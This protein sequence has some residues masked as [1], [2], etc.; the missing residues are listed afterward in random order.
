MGLCLVLVCAATGLWAQSAPVYGLFLGRELLQIGTFTEPNPSRAAYWE[1]WARG[2]A[3]GQLSGGQAVTPGNQSY[4]APADSQGAYLSEDFPAAAARDAEF[5][6]GAYSLSVTGANAFSATISLTESPAA[7]PAA[8][9]FPP[10]LMLEGIPAGRDVPLSWQ[11]GADAREGDAVMVALEDANGGFLFNTPWPGQPG[12]LSGLATSATLPG[13][14]LTPGNVLE[15]K[16]IVFRI[17]SSQ[18]LP[19]GGGL[20]MAGSATAVSEIVTVSSA[21]EGNDV[22]I[23]ELLEG[24]DFSQ[25]SQAVPVPD[26]NGP[27]A[28]EASAWASAA[29][30]LTNAAVAPP[31]LSPMPLGPVGS[32]GLLWRTNIAFGQ[33]ADLSAAFPAGVYSWAFDGTADG[34]QTASAT[35]AAGAWPQPLTVAN[36]SACQTNSFTNDFVVQWSAPANA[37]TNDYVEF[38]VLD[39]AQDEVFRTPNYGAGES[40]L[41]GTSTQVVIPA[42]TLYDGLDYEAQLR[43]VQVASTDTQSL[44]GATG[45]VGRYAETRFPLGTQ[46]GPPLEILTTNLPD[47]AVGE[48]Y[49][50]QLEASGGRPPLTWS[51]I[52]GSLP[53]ALATDSSGVIQGYPYTNGDFSLTVQATDSLGQTAQQPLLLSVTGVL[54]QLSF[55]ATNLP[56]VQD[57]LYYLVQLTASGGLGPLSWSIVSGQL[58]LGLELD[59]TTGLIGGLAQEAGSF[60]IQVALRDASGQT[61]IQS[62]VLD[63]P[64]VT[65][66]PVLRFTEFSLL[67]G[68]ALLLGLNSQAGE[69][70]TVEQSPD[71]GHWTALVTTNMPEGG[72]LELPMPQGTAA[73]YRA[74]RG[75]PQPVSNPLNVS[76][77]LD[78]NTTASALLTGSGLSLSLTNAAGQAWELDVPTNAVQDDTTIQMTALQAVAGLPFQGGLIGGVSFAPEGLSLL[79]PATL[80]MRLPAAVPADA[81]AFGFSGAGLN[82]QLYPA[83]ATNNTM[84]F[85]ILHFSGVGAA[86]ATPGETS[87][88]SATG[89]CNS[90]NQFKQLLAGLVGWGILSTPEDQLWTLFK[91]WFDGAIWPALQAAQEDDRLL[92]QAQNQFGEWDAFSQKY[93]PLSTGYYSTVHDLHEKGRSA[94]ARAFANAVNASEYRALSQLRPWQAYRMML[95]A[96]RARALGLNVELPGTFD[97]ALMTQRFLRDFVFWLE[98]PLSKV[99]VHSSG[100][101]YFGESVRTDP[102]H[103]AVF[104]PEGDE[105]Q[106]LEGASSAPLSYLTWREASEPP[107]NRPVPG[108]GLLS[109]I[110]LTLTPNYPPPSG[111]PCSTDPAWNDPLQPNIDCSFYAVDPIQNMEVWSK[112]KKAWV[113]VPALGGNWWTVFQSKH[114]LE[115]NGFRGNDAS[116]AARIGV[117]FA[118][119]LWEY[120][121]GAGFLF[122]RAVFSQPLT[123]S[124]GTIEEST[125]ISLWYMPIIATRPGSSLAHAWPAIRPGAADVHGGRARRPWRPRPD[126]SAFVRPR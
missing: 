123:D 3:P 89:A 49:A 112:S 101:G 56:V 4:A 121:G 72:E 30:R 107:E 111:D 9:S 78:T 91:A 94:L 122:A 38:V 16:L 40:P 104:W 98:L 120:F 95:V 118:T 106:P 119:P 41:P 109:G 87:K 79:N 17:A 108:E 96:N 12:A 88:L 27:Y 50:A 36:W 54:P 83:Q 33:E 44:P 116:G 34:H 110:Y 31:G 13:S 77:T 124:E 28:F 59:A 58:P 64:S 46:V 22:A 32:S 8:P 26:T 80:T 68:P 48:S 115:G 76:V 19:G 52:A 21:P 86:H 92:L 6:P 51:L 63:V 71:L 42:N 7:Y 100:G 55:A 74:Y 105:T 23:Y 65:N 61:Q 5:P 53:Q 57:G 125:A 10:T 113:E 47:A 45:F 99:Q 2:F 85:T 15:L 102:N 81:A 43:Y 11:P 103:Y 62:L 69:L 20:A 114:A 82:L 25:L 29:N 39:A 14:A 1:C 84:V 126:C 24:R 70:C 117:D 37:S 66:N 93:L 90:S 97:E 73:F 35:L 75:A 18:T 60:S 67:P